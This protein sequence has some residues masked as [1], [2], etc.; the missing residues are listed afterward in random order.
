[1]CG[2]FALKNPQ[3]LKAAFDLKEMPDLP[4]RYNIAPS[5]D[6]A[7]I[8]ADTSGRHLCMAHWGLIPSWAKE[9]D[10]GYSTINARAETVDTKPTFRVPF[11]RHRCI[12]PTDGFYEWHEEGGI[13]IP[14]HIGMKDGSPFALAGLWDVWKG[15]QGDVTSCTIIV[16]DANQFMKRLHD[17]MPVILDPND[18]ERWLD[19]AIQDTTSIKRLLAPAPNDWLTE[20]TV[21]RQ[22]N[23][24]RHEAPEC[25]EPVK[26]SLNIRNA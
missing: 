23:N 18:Y 26:E 4:P 22:L 24:P 2:R 20:W 11:K 15:P 17:R 6:I 7:I 1:M 19:P 10:S 3:A 25:A 9:A 5:Q 21:S 8:R 13:K 12:I 14:H 16:T